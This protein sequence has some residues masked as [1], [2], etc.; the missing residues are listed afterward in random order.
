MLTA[1]KLISAQITF[2]D[3]RWKCIPAAYLRL[4]RPAD[5]LK[6]AEKAISVDGRYVKALFRRAQALEALER[7]SDAVAAYE[8]GLTVMPDS[9][10]LLQG[11]KSAKEKAEKA[12]AADM[13]NR[14]PVAPDPCT[15]NTNLPEYRFEKA[16]EN[17]IVHVELPGREN[18]QGVDLELFPESLS[19]SAP[20]FAALSLT[21][22]FPVDYEKAKAKFVKKSRTLR[23]TIPRV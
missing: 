18:M 5:A 6:D 16:D 1:L 10:Q 4:S 15:S 12:S 14:A 8:H 22:P 21:L 17:L 19:L 2:T 13:A 11:L 7:Y 20:P 23:I 9:D 3:V